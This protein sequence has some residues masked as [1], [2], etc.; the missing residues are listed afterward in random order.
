MVFKLELKK[1]LTLPTVLGLLIMC[2]FL[3]VILIFASDKKSYLP[4]Q[5]EEVTNIFE[6][7]QTVKIADSYLAKD[8]VTGENA[9]NIQKKYAWLQPI[10]EKKAKTKE[11]LDP[12]FKEQTPHHHQLLFK[13]LFRVIIGEVALF[14]LFFPLISLS[15]D[16]SQGLEALLSTTKVGRRLPVKK[17]FASLTA[18]FLIL[19]CL[20]AL[21]LSLFFFRFDF[22][23]VWQDSVSSAYNSAVFEPGKP[24]ITW[25]SLTVVQYL[26][27]TIGLTFLL[28]LFFSLLGYFV[29]VAISKSLPAF[30]TLI[31]FLVLSYLLKPLFP[32]GSHLRGIFAMSPF[33]LWKNSGEWFTDG[34][35]DILWPYFETLGVISFTLVFIGLAIM[36]TKRYQRREI[37]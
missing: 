14:A 32:V 21:S 33:W 13:T 24:F 26:F 22:S 4:D 34:T 3:N 11:A 20:L 30:M 16:K 7:F 27:Q 18:S 15:F 29:S 23:K 1:L 19:F 5:V 37:L 10:V 2:L 9:K 35:S 6:N 36:G 25:Q 8:Q 12:Y 31:S 28:A 17:F